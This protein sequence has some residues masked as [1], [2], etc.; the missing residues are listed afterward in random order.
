MGGCTAKSQPLSGDFGEAS[1]KLTHALS[2]FNVELLGIR[3]LR[4]SGSATP[5][6][7]ASTCYQMI[8]YQGKEMSLRVSK[9]RLQS[10]SLAFEHSVSVYEKFMVCMCSQFQCTPMARTNHSMNGKRNVQTQRKLTVIHLLN[11]RRLEGQKLIS[12]RLLTKTNRAPKWM[13]RV[14]TV[15]INILSPIK[16]S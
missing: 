3:W 9:V 14:R 13:E 15:G 12:K 1:M 6:L 16:V 10:I 5:T 8:L 4:P 11:F 7:K 2:S